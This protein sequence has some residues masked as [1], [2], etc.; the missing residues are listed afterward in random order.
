[1]TY[2]P[3]P[4]RADEVTFNQSGIRYIESGCYGSIMVLPAVCVSL[5]EIFLNIVQGCV[6]DGS[7]AVKKMTQAQQSEHIFSHSVQG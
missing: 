2:D 7:N 6:I 1:M 3:R 5:V 4:F